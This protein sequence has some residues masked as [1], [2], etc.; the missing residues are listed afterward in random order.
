MTPYSG[1]S[2]QTAK[3]I[4][5]GYTSNGVLSREIKFSDNESRLAGLL[6][7]IGFQF[8]KYGKTSFQKNKV[9]N[10]QK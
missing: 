8:F 7:A 6:S 10:E 5:R 9:S 4:Q 2:I 3:E 1:Q